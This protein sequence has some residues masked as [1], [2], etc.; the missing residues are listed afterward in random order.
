MND[1]VSKKLIVIISIV[2]WETSI[3]FK[4]LNMSKVFFNINLDKAK[5]KLYMTPILFFSAAFLLFGF[6][7]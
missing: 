7:D 5:W 4:Y 1:G 3:Q 6:S 2:L